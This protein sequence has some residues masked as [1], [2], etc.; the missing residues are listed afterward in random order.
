MQGHSGQETK[1]KTTAFFSSFRS[2]EEV[3]GEEPEASSVSAETERLEEAAVR[4]ANNGATEGGVASSA[5]AST[6]FSLAMTLATEASDLNALL[7]GRKN[8]ARMC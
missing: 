2:D 1:T 5:A 3:I 4:G 8:R 7:R 6:A